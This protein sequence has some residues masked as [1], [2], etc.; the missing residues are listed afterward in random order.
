MSSV[1]FVATAAK[2]YIYQRIIR[3]LTPFIVVPLLLIFGAKVVF[4]GAAALL[5]CA[6][7]YIAG[8]YLYDFYLYGF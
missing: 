7:L 4:I 8:V 3:A 5:V 1:E 6:A 2:Y